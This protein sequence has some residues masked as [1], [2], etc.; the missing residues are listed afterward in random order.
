VLIKKELDADDDELTRTRKVRRGFVEDRYREL[1][2]AHY[3]DKDELDIETDI[4]YKDGKGFR[5]KTRVKVK[6]V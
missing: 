2:E 4:Q 1:I 3:S 6:Q 5:M